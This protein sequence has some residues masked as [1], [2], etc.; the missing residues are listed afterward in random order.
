MNIEYIAVLDSGVGGISVLIEL[1]KAFPYERFLYYGDNQN[2]PYG[3]LNKQKLLSLSIHN[4]NIIKSYPIKMIVL[5]CNTL[6]VNLINEIKEYSG[7]PTLGVFPPVESCLISGKSTIL[8]STIRTAENY[9]SKYNFESVGFFDLASEIEKNLF[10]LEKVNFLRCKTKGKLDIAKC[11]KGQ[12]EN[13]ILG[14]THY[15]FIKNQ[16]FDHFQPQKLLDGTSNLISQMQPIIKK[17]KS[18]VICCQNSPLFIGE[19]AKTNR[20]FYVR[21]GQN[22]S[23]FLKKVVKVSKNIKKRVDSGQKLW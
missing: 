14:C 12:F 15:N 9:K 8:L 16:I 5:A 4:I 3:N 22:N 6:S 18:S 10:S 21:S 19:N 2:S 7:V 11:K 23:N 17:Q 1:Q 13:V 20:L